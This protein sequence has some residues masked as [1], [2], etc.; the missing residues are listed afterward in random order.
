MNYWL[1]LVGVLCLVLWIS[2][3]NDSKKEIIEDNIKSNTSTDVLTPRVQTARAR[4]APFELSYEVNGTIKAYKRI[5]I[6]S[7]ISGW[8]SSFHLREG[9]Y[10]KKGDLLAR[11]DDQDQQH[12]IASLEVALADVTHNRNEQRMLVS[13]GYYGQDSLL[14]EQ[15]KKNIDHRMGYNKAIQELENARFRSKKALIYSPISG[16]IADRKVLKGQWITSGNSLCTVINP[17]SHE[18]EIMVLESIALQLRKHQKIAIQAMG[19]PTL[20]STATITTINPVV[21]PN[22]LVKVKAKLNSGHKRYYEGM[23]ISAKILTKTP[24]YIIVPK[25]ALVVRS[26]RQVIFTYDDKEHLAKW[27]YVSIAH[28]NHVDLAIS[29]GLQEGDQVIIKGNLNLAHDASVQIEA[30]TTTQD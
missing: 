3:N 25:E 10:I 27:K 14:S 1:E 29:E 28:E 11:L 26:G 6:Q 19:D 8:L 21:D 12:E 20:S 7:E 18:A 2:C 30:H 15:Q 17:Y 23:N 22:G 16:I 5:E 13:G 24:A 9:D 4:R